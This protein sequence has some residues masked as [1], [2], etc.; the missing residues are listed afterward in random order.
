M[1]IVS[2]EEMRTIDAKAIQEYK[3]PGLLLMD[4]AA[5]AVADEVKAMLT[6]E[7][8][9]VVVVCGKGNNGG[10][11][12]GAARWLKSAGVNV[13]VL[14]IDAKAENLS[15]DAAEEAAMYVAD[16]GEIIEVVEEDDW[17]VA[18]IT[19]TKADIIVD[20][21]LGTGFAGELREAVQHAAQ[22]INSCKQRAAIVAVDVPSGVN[23]NDGSA[24]ND[25]VVADV[26]LCFG[27]VKEGLLLFPAREKTGEI[28]LIDIGYPNAL[29]QEEGTGKYM[30]TS[31]IVNKLMPARAANAHKGDAGRVVVCAGSPGFVG[32]AALASNAAVKAGAG[33]VSL[34]TPLSSQTALAVKL[35]E[36]M[37]HGLLERMPGALGGAAVND[38]VTAANQA[39]ILAIGPGLGQAAS[40]QEVVL[41]ILEKAEVP[42]VIDADALNAV[43]TKIEILQQMQAPKVVTPHPGEMARLTG[44]T[45]EEIDRNRIEIAEKYAKEWNAVVV[46]KG[47]PTV[48]A[49]PEGSIY[50]NTTGTSAL[51]TGG[52]GD[53][54]TGIIAGLAA[55]GITLQEAAI[56]GVYLHGLAGNIACEAEYGLAA[57]EIADQ[58]SAAMQAVK[59]GDTAME[60]VIR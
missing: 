41:S 8:D 2:T 31:A 10:D 1:R 48:V 34:Y 52:T 28:K 16:G 44:L 60:F 4:Q 19:L 37:V 12:F 35:T 24:A 20:A 27:L 23:S 47:A 58:L 33:L 49:G 54:L 40:T 13:K 29:L 38:V 36:V 22:L 14:L 57:G 42:V 32:A 17:L 6:D 53:V 25:A 55:Q 59:T 56:C 30:I 15:G 9:R 45:I 3:I 50:V 46:L 21:I 43:A 39:D 11:G 5:R 7:A 51:A 18:E 26:T